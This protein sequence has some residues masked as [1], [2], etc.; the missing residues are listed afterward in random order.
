MKFRSK[1]KS[2][3]K[4]G[5]GTSE[6]PIL[7]QQLPC[8]DSVKA[9]KK[10]KRLYEQLKIENEEVI[11]QN[12]VLECFLDAKK[13]KIT[14]LEARLEGNIVEMDDQE[15]LDEIP[16]ST[17]LLQDDKLQGAINER[18]EM[19]S[20]S[21]EESNSSDSETNQYREEPHERLM[22]GI[23]KVEGLNGT[24][25]CP[26]CDDNEKQ[27]YDYSSLFHHAIGFAEGSTNLSAKQK[28]SHL[29]L[30]EYLETYLSNSA[31]LQNVIPASEA[32]TVKKDL[33]YW[34]WVGIIAYILE[35]PKEDNCVVSCGYWLKKFS[36]F[37]PLEVE[38]FWDVQREAAYA[39]VRF[40]NDWIG[41]KNAMEFEK[42]FEAEGQSKKEW[43]DR[44]TSPC[45]CIY[46][47]QARE[48]DYKSEGPV[49]DYLRRRGGLKT[50][51]DLVLESTIDRH[52]M[53]VKLFNE[54][55]L[56]NENLDQLQIKYNELKTSLGR[57]HDER[58]E[59]HKAFC[60]EIKNKQLFTL[61]NIRRISEEQLTLISEIK[62]LDACSRDLNKRE[63]L[64]DRERQKL[65]EEKT[66]NNLRKSVLQNASEERKKVED[67]VLR[68]LEEHKEEAFKKILEL[69]RN[70]DEKQKLEME[71]QELKGKL[72][73]ME[74][75]RG[76][77]DAGAQQKIDEMKEQLEEKI[78]D[79]FDREE[80]N[81]QL[82]AKERE[83][84]DELQE[85]RKELIAGLIDL[86][87]SNR[88][89]IGIKRMGELDEK[90]FK[91]ACKARFSP[92]KADIKAA[93]LCSM[94][95]ESMKESDWYPFQII[96]DEKGDPK[97]LLKEDDE[98]LCSL[99][100]EWG[101][102]VYE[103]VTT[104]LTELREYNPSGCYVVP[105]LWNFKENRKATLKEVIHYIF[106]RL[107][108][109]N[110]KRN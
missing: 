79:L 47:W 39:V 3:A 84:N 101:S 100:N 106:T 45:S 13:M 48:D 29:A 82:L 58:D 69:E 33:F 85:A 43:D 51:S 26:F 1:S 53:V 96:K 73:V 97:L 25:R 18:K 74:H 70:L 44:R 102:E 24:L 10:W 17:E 40:D 108:T 109:L 54:I 88:V 107:K 72:E 49:G 65:E 4:D 77:D 6:N 83:S 89:S 81:Q 27:G 75:L 87:S 5:E 7:S 32:K 42:F 20:S 41:F 60:E 68:L 92:D 93:E 90:P 71:I 31:L 52:N 94:W 110:R 37:K 12:L 66:K 55:D 38:N 9:E 15:D 50:I 21:S 22:T 30:A 36:K 62:H 14:E 19:G 64:A 16:S 76:E 61:E 103:A 67:N 56:K 95:Q 91:T 46:G 105:E 80:L 28:G 98:R 57:I 63:A 59:I 104:A 23:S 11:K 86:L 34:P 2:A 8:H 35:D 99:K 78:E